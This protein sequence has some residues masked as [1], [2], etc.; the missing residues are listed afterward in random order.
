M[1]RCVLLCLVASIAL[2]ACEGSRNN[3]SWSGAEKGTD[4]VPSLKTA[5]TA[6]TS[7]VDPGTADSSEVNN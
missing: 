7:A 1:R 6:D 2:V 4:V 5:E 3:T